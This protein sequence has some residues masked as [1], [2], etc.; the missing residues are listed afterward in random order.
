MTRQKPCLIAAPHT[1]LKSSFDLNLAMVD[2]QAERFASTGVKGVFPG[3]TTGE[4][5]S[6]SHE[7]R[8]RLIQKWCE[9][10]KNSELEVIPHVGGNCIEEAKSLASCAERCGA[11]G[12]GAMAPSFFPPESIE[13]LVDFCAGVA[14][15]A[16][17]TDFYFY[18]IPSRTGV[19]FPMTEFLA[20]GSE[21][22][23]TLA[24]LKFTHSDLM[25]E[26]LCVNYREE[27]FRILHGFDETLLAGLT[28]GAAGAV[29][30]TYNFA[31]KLYLQIIDA[32]LAGDQESAI[33]L[34]RQSATI[35][36]TMQ[37]Y[38]FMQ[39]SKAV[40]AILGIDCGPVRPPLKPIETSQVESL[41]RDLDSIA[42]FDWTT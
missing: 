21:R 38:G 17:S 19:E 8:S 15:A 3:G 9:S 1:P 26:M 12:I 34:Q 31:A 30:S 32:F 13:L 25:Q 14:A 7:E 16:P 29:G 35:V 39:A 23:P 40:M 11:D 36:R 37:K 41:R 20:I 2:A 28:V 5:L 4:S 24:G 22:I 18:H 27:K 6:L 42:F 10:G 33:R